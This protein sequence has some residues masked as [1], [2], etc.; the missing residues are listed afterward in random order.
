MRRAPL[1]ITLLLALASVGS[2]QDTLPGILPRAEMD[3]LLE[4][5]R[6][7]ANDAQTAMRERAKLLGYSDAEIELALKPS[8]VRRGHFTVTL[9]DGTQ[10]R[11]PWF[12][13]GFAENAN[14]TE[15]KGVDRGRT[16]TNKGGVR[17]HKG[18]FGAEVYALA[19]KMDAKLAITG[20]A[21][22]GESF[23]GAKGGIGAGQVVKVGTQFRS[24]V[25][26]WVDP[27]SKAL[28]RAEMMRS[29]GNGYTSGGARVGLGSDIQA[30]DVNTKAPEMKVLSE[31]YGKGNPSIGVSG[32]EVIL[33]PNGEI[34]PRGGIEY[35]AVSTGE[36]VWMSS[37]LAGQAEGLDL[38]RATVASQGWGEVGKGFG[39]AAVREGSR[40]IGIQELWF[41]DGEMRPGLL[42]HPKGA[43]ATQAEV[44]AWLK[45]VEALRAGKHDLKTFKNGEMA[46]QFTLNGDVSKMKVD[47]VGYN[48]LG[49]VLNEST[50]PELA[51]SGTHQGKRKII[52]EGANLAETAEGARLLDRYKGRLLTIPGDLANL[53][54][55]HVSNL[56]AVQ[57]RFGEVVT[58][59]EARRSLERTMESG[60]ERALELAKKHGV[61]ERKAIELLAVDE[62]M[63]RSLQRPDATKTNVEKGVISKEARARYFRSLAKPAE[64]LAETLKRFRR[65]DG[66]LDWK[67]I[68]RGGLAEAGG[69]AHFGM[70]LFLKE[71]AVVAGTGDKAR[72]EEFFEGLMTTDF[73]KQYGLFVAGARVGEVA[74]VRYLQRYVRPGFV[75]G[76]LKTNL[77]LA[78]GL[79]LPALVEGRFEGKAFAISLGALGI[80]SGAVRTGVQGLKWVMNLKKARK[81]GLL[82]KVGL[83]GG[84]LARFGGWFYTA[85]ELAVVL[86]FAE[87]MD[88]SANEWL[89]LE[90]ARETLG[91]AG[92]RFIDAVNDPQAKPEGVRAASDAYHQAWIDYRDYLYGP[93]HASEAALAYKMEKL[94]V[95]AKLEED[96][97]QAALKNL[98]KTPNLAKNLIKRYG[99]IEGYANHLTAKGNAELDTK[100]NGLLQSYEQRR[101][102]QLDAVYKDDR[103]SEPFLADLPDVDWSLRGAR[104]DDADDPYQGRTDTFA[105]HARKRSRAALE[106][107]LAGGSKNRLQAYEDEASVY[108]SLA[109]LFRDRGQRD[110]ADEFERRMTLAKATG[111]AD[112]ALYE[113]GGAI[114]ARARKG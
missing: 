72:I 30:G 54:G 11:F 21:S 98:A 66:T 61:S 64:A 87:K 20:D 31:T 105:R 79:A 13:I 28:N 75:N 74:Y 23:R 49:Q 22:S 93:L 46:K 25:G 107:A 36:G 15:S 53:G 2:A 38:K 47:I 113:N 59:D 39:M 114:D 45:D 34:S 68:R 109:T 42:Q 69:L 100:V 50:V 97:R 82:A 29:F 96:K 58:N 33:G 102:E 44:E 85:A 35:R 40:V 86:Y 88:I 3:G 106:A 27:A 78:A 48:A 9:S 24:K 70:A 17:L 6:G 89:D 10:I 55:V 84:R 4:E 14:A 43:N 91:E 1:T 62:M 8:M 73:Y 41:V 101:R 63:K 103:R 80:S 56:E 90:K 65:A 18:V 111:I 5:A 32:K 99:S 104:A 94:A 37:K 76:M 19:L 112:S 77:V 12:R 92:L 16:E 81:V 108:A 51:G 83:R 52:T 7:Q 26:D 71:L 67:G 110:L 95:E 60:W 57:N